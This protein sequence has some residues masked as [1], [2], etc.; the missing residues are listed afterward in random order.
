MRHRTLVGILLALVL[1]L[2]ATAFAASPAGFVLKDNKKDDYGD[3]ILKY[4]IRNDMREGDLDLV[5]LSA[6]PSSDG[7]WFTVVMRRQIRKP[8]ATVVDS[9]GN[10]ADELARLGFY[11]FNVDIYIDTDRVEGSGQTWPMP[12]RKVTLDP[13]TAWEKVIALT[14]QPEQAALLVRNML[15]KTAKAEV[16]S[17]KAHSDAED[18]KLAREYAYNALETDFFFPRSVQVLGN[19]I[20]FFVPNGFLQGPAR[21]EW[22]YTVFVTGAN[23]EGRFDTAAFVGSWWLETDFLLI[24]VWAGLSDKHF[25]GRDDDKL[26]PPIVDLIVPAGQTQEE[27]LKSYDL[28]IDKK[29]Q[30][31]GVVPQP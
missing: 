16:K 6:E 25:A 23:L 1:V 31:T 2:P 12:G 18:S 3:G 10:Q 21:P 5:E 27:I 22:A 7:T 11:T 9:V 30:L 24:P 28:R 20:K 19:K 15:T 14:P 8:P 17:K 4:P 26:Q 13:K 29:V